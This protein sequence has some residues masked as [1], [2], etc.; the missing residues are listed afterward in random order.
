MI[1]EVKDNGDEYWKLRLLE[2]AQSLKIL[3]S[4]EMHKMGHMYY[5]QF[6]C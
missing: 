1:R 4:M 3:Q 6:A 2:E 5:I